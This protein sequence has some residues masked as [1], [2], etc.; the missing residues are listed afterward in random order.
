MPYCARQEALH[1]LQCLLEKVLELTVS[2]CISICYADPRMDNR[3][4]YDKIF[5]EIGSLKYSVKIY[6]SST[7]VLKSDF[8]SNYTH[9][10]KGLTHGEASV[11]GN[12]MH[13]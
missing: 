4:Y 12:Y 13:H 6:N 11:T 8:S 7:E 3:N 2:A 1:K 9:C 10:K 5:I